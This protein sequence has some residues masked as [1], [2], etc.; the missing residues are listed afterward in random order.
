MVPVV[1]WFTGLFLKTATV[2]IQKEVSFN[3]NIKP[4]TCYLTVFEESNWDTQKL[5]FSKVTKSL[6]STELFATF[7]AQKFQNRMMCHS[8]MK[9]HRGC[10]L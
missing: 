1:N 8:G 5:Q 4:L 6:K 7:L 2:D 10:A 3:L 9:L